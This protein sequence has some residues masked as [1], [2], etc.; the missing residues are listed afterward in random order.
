MSNLK[1][2]WSS[3]NAEHLSAIANFINRKH[4][5][6]SW[7]RLTFSYITLLIAKI[8]MKY[9]VR[10]E[11]RLKCVELQTRLFI[12]S[13]ALFSRA[14]MYTPFFPFF[15]LLFCFRA[16]IF[17]MLYTEGRIIAKALLSQRKQRND[18]C[19]FWQIQCMS[20]PRYTVM[21]KPP[22]LHHNSTHL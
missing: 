2:Y 20:L 21:N 11:K 22:G 6:R 1:K 10:H 5:I 19:L 16:N 4:G 8:S 17:I 14:C 18:V 15:S 7:N 12:D 13:N 9:V 3:F